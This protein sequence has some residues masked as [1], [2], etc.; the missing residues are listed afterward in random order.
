MSQTGSTEQI[1]RVRQLLAKAKKDSG[2]TEAERQSSYD[3]AMKL[4]DKYQLSKEQV[5]A[6]KPDR[7]QPKTKTRTP[8]AGSKGP[9]EYRANIAIIA[10]D[11]FIK[12]KTKLE[13]VGVKV[14]RTDDHIVVKGD[15]YHNISI[16]K[17][18]A[19]QMYQEVVVSE[20]LRRRAAEQKRQMEEFDRQEREYK[21]R[22][23]EEKVKAE[24]QKLKFIK[25]FVTGIGLMVF[26]FIGVMIFL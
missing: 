1:Q 10:H 23:A 9:W 5:Y 11:D 22:K 20:H 16:A 8:P 7:V 14:I 21:R 6:V 17:Q 19:D 24:A 25:G 18:W 12:F 2:G 3:M 4:M 15:N 13:E 26:T